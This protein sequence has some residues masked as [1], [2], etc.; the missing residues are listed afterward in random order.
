MKLKSI[1]SFLVYFQL[2]LFVFLPGGS[3]YGVNIKL[4]TFLIFTLL[5][6]IF[7][8][9]T[10][11]D[12]KLYL[13]LSALF[14]FISF[15]TFIA[16]LPYRD[17]ANS[18][19][20]VRLFAITAFYPIVVWYFLKKNVVNASSLVLLV[21]RSHILF[22]TLKLFFFILVLTNIWQPNDI[23]VLIDHVFGVKV[24]TIE[25]LPNITRIQL[26]LDLISLIVFPILL[27]S[28]EFGIKM[29]G[30]TQ[31]LYHS[32]IFTGILISF[33]RYILVSYVLIFAVY[34]ILSLK[35][36]K[37]VVVVT[38]IASIVLFYTYDIIYEIAEIRFSKRISTSSDYVRTQQ[39]SALINEFSQNKIF[40]NGF[41]G[42]SKEVIRDQE[43]IFSYELQ[44]LSFLMKF[45]IIG[46]ALI[47]IVIAVIALPLFK[48]INFRLR[49]LM[50][51]VY[52]LWIA[53]N[54]FNPY[55]ISSMASVIFVV[56]IAL[57]FLLSRE[58]D[59][60]KERLVRI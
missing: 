4:F 27:F 42:Y 53:S 34:T 7:L 56:F 33:S 38:F 20:E 14:L 1:L 5:F 44:L 35:N 2:F 41:G 49:I 3:I 25:I 37:F 43:E 24:M 48:I 57:P 23:V 6:I 46:F 16:F 40:G 30:L 54:I 60:P 32:I 52:V 31:L 10:K 51:L 17:S 15:F 36:F 11:V 58:E 22:L 19:T 47:M 45:G 18:F 12:I 13:F 55:I 39:Y 26:N 8:A 59:S 28:K 29:N 50:I 9:T 21:I